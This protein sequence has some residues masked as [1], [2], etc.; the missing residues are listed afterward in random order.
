MDFN[1]F[2]CLDYAYQAGKVGGSLPTVLNAANEEAVAAFLQNKISFLQ[3]ENLIENA[4]EKHNVI[5]KPSLEEIRN[6][7]DQTRQFVSSLIK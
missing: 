1:R 5:S 3:I 6:I 7:D 4:L 2:K